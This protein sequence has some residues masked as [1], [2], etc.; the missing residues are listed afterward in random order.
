MGRTLGHHIG[1]GELARRTGLSKTHVSKVFNGQRRP[2][3][4]NARK[5]AIA[6]SITLDE[7]YEHLETLRK[8]RRA[9]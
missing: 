7:L 4:R 1:I 3:L 8:P 6:L 9:A 2:S 5:I